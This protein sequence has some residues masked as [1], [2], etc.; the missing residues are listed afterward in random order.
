MM[1]IISSY[2]HMAC[3]VELHIGRTEYSYDIDASNYEIIS[4]EK[5]ND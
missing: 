5:D 1:I 3:E 2:G 4:W